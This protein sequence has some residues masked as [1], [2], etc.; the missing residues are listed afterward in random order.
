MSAV[1][2][3]LRCMKE[4]QM[5]SLALSQ[6]NFAAPKVNS[7]SMEKTKSKLTD[8]ER[9]RLFE[10]QVIPLM[11]NLYGLARFKG[12]D[13]NTAEDYVQETMIKAFK[14]FDQFE[15]GTNIK[16]WLSTILKN[17]ML[18][19]HQK[20]N[21]DKAERGL[22]EMEDYK[23]GTAT[24][25]TAT[26]QRSAELEAIEN[27]PAQVIQD[28]LKR[29]PEK[30]RMVVYYA[31]VEGLKYS[32]I[33]ELLDMKDGTVMSSLHRGKAELREVLAEYAKE[34]GYDVSKSRKSEK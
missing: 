1:F 33:A 32:E 29:L 22:E 28:A 6:R 12:A 3:S 24:S 23:L 19:D 9:L 25:L 8:K 11:P 27:M 34:Q 16:A 5:A 17:T 10:E 4:G 30:R 26:S 31:I 21:R 13:V 20:N 18:N 7:K 14:A 2:I 15:Q